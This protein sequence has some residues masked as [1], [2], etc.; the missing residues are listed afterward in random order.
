M[1]KLIDTSK[2][3]TIELDVAEAHTIQQALTLYRKH[4]V[5]EEAV[6]EYTH[7]IANKVNTVYERY[8]S[9]LNNGSFDTQEPG[10]RAMVE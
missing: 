3:Y 4:H 2:K 5:K 1:A 9:D 6:Y 7:M 8:A 10:G